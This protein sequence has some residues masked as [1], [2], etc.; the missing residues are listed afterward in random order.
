MPMVGVIVMLSSPKPS[1][2]ARSQRK[3]ALTGALLLMAS[4]AVAL[5]FFAAS[6]LAVVSTLEGRPYGVTP[7]SVELPANHVGEPP[8]FEPALFDNT[9]GNAVVKSSNVYAI[10]WD[11]S[12]YQYHSDWQ[13]VIDG[14][15]HNLGAES[16]SLISTF[17]VDTQYVDKAN[18]R[19]GYSITFR[20]A[21]T[22]TDPY[23]THPCIDPAPLHL[24]DAVT[25][26]TDAQ[27]QEELKSYIAQH[28]LQTGM[29]TIFYVLTPPGVTL[30][31]DG[32]GVSGHCSDYAISG[33]PKVTKE[34]FKRSFCSYH[35]DINPTASTEGDASTILYAAIPWTAG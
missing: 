4:L 21:Y 30:C 35:S 19:G 32:G 12:G 3:N 23:P 26:I 29:N 1:S 8:A 14:F 10:Y 27:V 15:L 5:G 6:A 13:H 25:C 31:L 16:G 2:R 24:G 22:D 17:A 28:A 11:P 9:E 18:H 33:E 34:N 20:G 7:R